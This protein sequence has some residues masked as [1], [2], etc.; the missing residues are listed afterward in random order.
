[1]CVYFAKLIKNTHFFSI[2]LD[3]YVNRKNFQTAGKCADHNTWN[4]CWRQFD[5][6][7]FAYRLCHVCHTSIN[8]YRLGRLCLNDDTFMHIEKQFRMEN[9]NWQRWERLRALS[10]NGENDKILWWRK[11]I[12]F[13]GEKVSFK[14]KEHSNKSQRFIFWYGHWG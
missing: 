12:Q 1:M 2:I 7:K 3:L 4:L 13:D 10:R 9:G 8:N 5:R 11:S 14:T 6:Q